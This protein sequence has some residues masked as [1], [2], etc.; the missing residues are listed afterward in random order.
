[1]TKT[2][3]G[4]AEHTSRSTDHCLFPASA[5]IVCLRDH[6]GRYYNYYGTL[7]ALFAEG[8]K[9]GGV[10]ETNIVSS[11]GTIDRIDSPNSSKYSISYACG[12]MDWTALRGRHYHEP[13]FVLRFILAGENL[14]G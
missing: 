13:T 11:D 8:K 2:I 5:W 14:S 6:P 4:L 9:S 12:V 1:M 3:S 10:N 7:T